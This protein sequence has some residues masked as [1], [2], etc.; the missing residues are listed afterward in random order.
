M[1]LIMKY[2]LFT[3]L[4]VTRLFSTYYI[5]ML[6]SLTIS[7]VTDLCFPLPLYS[8]RVK[9]ATWFYL[10]DKTLLILSNIQYR[11]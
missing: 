6:Y 3:L 10:S 1:L 5:Y 9:K 11:S 2:Y 8:T 4:I 7:I